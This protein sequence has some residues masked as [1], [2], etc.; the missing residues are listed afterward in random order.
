MAAAAG[1]PIVLYDGVCALCNRMV[2]FVL[3][4]DAAGVFRFASLQSGMARQILARHGRDPDDLDTL[5]V[6]VDP[7]R[8][9]ERLLDRSPAVVFVLQQLPR[10][11]RVI[12]AILRGVPAPLRN[13]G[14]RVIAASRYR[15]FG[16]YDVCPLPVPEHRRRFLDQ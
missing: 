15:A 6:V 7:G 12:G 5:V 16:R 9:S 3:A 14:Y 8:P 4:R 11:W 13:L 1:G 10:R 2:R